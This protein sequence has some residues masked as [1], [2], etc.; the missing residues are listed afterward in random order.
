MVICVFFCLCTAES[1]WQEESALNVSKAKK[2]SVLPKTL[3][4]WE[5]VQQ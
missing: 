5:I 4:A 2:K 3:L 1:N